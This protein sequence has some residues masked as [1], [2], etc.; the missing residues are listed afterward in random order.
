MSI[1]TPGDPLG[2]TGTPTGTVFNIDGGATGGFTVSG[3]DKNG[4]P[5]TA[6]A[7]FLFATE[8]GTLVG[9]NPAVNPKGFDPA[10]AGTYGI[11][12][13]DNSGNNFTEADPAK[14]TG[15]VYKGLTIASSATPGTPIFASDPNTTTVLYAANFR[16]GKV[17]VYD[18]NFKSVTLTAGAFADPNLPK[19]FAP[20]NVQV[21]GGKVYVTYAKQDANKHDDVAGQGHG[22]I[23]VFNLDGTPG[24]P[25]GKE[26]LV[27]RGPLDSPWGL[28]L[29]PSSF[30]G[31]GGDLLVGNFGSGLIDV[32][33]PT[34]GEVPGQPERLR[35]QA[36][37]DRRAVGAAGRQ[38]RQRRRRQHGVLHRRPRPR[39][40]RPVRLA[41]AGGAGGRRHRRPHVSQ[42]YFPDR[43]QP[44]RDDA[45]AA[46]RQRVELREALS[47]TRSTATSMPS[48]W[49]SARC[50]W[51]TARSTTS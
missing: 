24:L 7:V 34:T 46:E 4:N 14:Q 18:T 15:A 10:K 37:P 21:L 19:G 51:A 12:A 8:D 9:W 36:H 17:E 41:D 6:S 40:A 2:A 13:V 43:G 27:S 28:A 29:A 22:F 42:R 16:S 26:R 3:V 44:E 35:R 45:D 39:D 31:L 48:P 25:G 50:A 32:F 38:R 1:P 20:F 33:N 47:T 11:I 5:I 23:D 49:R 30:G